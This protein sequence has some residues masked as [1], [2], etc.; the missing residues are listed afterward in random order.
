MGQDRTARQ[1][2]CTCKADTIFRAS[3]TSF[4]KVSLRGSSHP[5]STAAQEHSVTNVPH[6]RPR[7]NPD[8]QEPEKLT[9]FCTSGLLKP[10]VL[11]S[12]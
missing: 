7:I 5:V 10:E 8:V 9:M 4:S 2:A 6:K 12:V 1:S 3:S 11:L